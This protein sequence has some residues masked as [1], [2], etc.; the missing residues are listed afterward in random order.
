MTAHDGAAVVCDAVDRSAPARR[1]T[2]RALEGRQPSHAEFDPKVWLGSRVDATFYRCAELRY[3][4]IDP[5]RL[6]KRRLGDSG[7]TARALSEFYADRT[8]EFF[9]AF[10]VDARNRVIG[11]CIIGQGGD[12]S[13]PVAA[14]E[15]ARFLVLAGAV[16]FVVFHNHPTGDPRPSPEDVALT[17]RVYELGKNIGIKLLDHVIL[18]DDKHTSL[19]DIMGHLFKDGAP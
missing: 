14:P 15:L 7:D 9:G 12:A 17:R 3:R 1:G 16:G 10:A 6:A 8:V 11:H 18:A 19:L 13:T 4:K 5:E 2:R